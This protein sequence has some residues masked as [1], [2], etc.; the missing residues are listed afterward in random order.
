MKKTKKLA[1]K[2]ETSTTK[3]SSAGISKKTSCKKEKGFTKS[4]LKHYEDI[5]LKEKYRL[6]KEL[7]KIEVERPPVGYQ[8][9]PGEIISMD[10]DTTDSASEMTEA[11]RIVAVEGNIHKILS[12]ID[13]SLLKI[14][15]GTYGLCDKC[16]AEIGK[17]RLKFIPYAILCVECKSKEEKNLQ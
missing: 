14:K 12:E 13:A 17:T 9:A 2:K 15:Q 5:L 1:Q 10:D 7:G 11:D 8:G 4:E 16:G 3:E 6:L